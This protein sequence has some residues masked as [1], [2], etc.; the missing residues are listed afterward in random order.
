MSHNGLRTDRPKKESENQKEESYKL[1]P[2]FQERGKRT[3]KEIDKGK[4]RGREHRKCEEQKLG[5]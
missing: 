3:E 1:L 2:V 5:R 4:R